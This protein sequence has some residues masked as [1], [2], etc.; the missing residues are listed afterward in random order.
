M[1]DP[2]AR[3]ALLIELLEKMKNA[4]SWCGE[5]HLQKS[6]YFL[7]AGYGVPLDLTFTLYKH[8][9]FSFELR[10][11]LGEMRAN[12][13]IDVESRHPFGSSF[14]VSEPGL[15]LRQ[16]FPKTIARYDDQ[17]AIVA[18]ELSSSDVVTL[19]RLSTALYVKRMFPTLS[20][21][22][23]AEKITA[24]KPHVSLESASGAVSRIEELGLID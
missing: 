12:F 20:A 10:E 22:E 15:A 1:L 19:E 2:F 11:V 6:A 4:G 3:Q 9:P 8:G 18:Q 5:T 13:L 7:Q 21:P 23:R 16:R 14:D 24:L 17:I